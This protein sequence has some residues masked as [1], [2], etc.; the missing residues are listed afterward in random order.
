MNAQC[1]VVFVALILS[2]WTRR[3]PTLACAEVVLNTR[4]RKIQSAVS[5]SLF[6]F[7]VNSVELTSVRCRCSYLK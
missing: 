6:T 7:L 5:V 1:Q 3:I 4:S 2:A